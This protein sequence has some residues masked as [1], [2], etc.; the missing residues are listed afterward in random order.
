MKEYDYVSDYHDGFA[1]VKL[2]DKYG[3]I[4]C[5]GQEICLIKYDKMWSFINGFAEVWIGEEKFYIDEYG[6]EY[7]YKLVR[8]NQ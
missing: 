1:K 7:E 8:R 3:A 5:K 4:N 2:N 6:I